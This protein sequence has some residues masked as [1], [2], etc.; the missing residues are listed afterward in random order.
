MF[1]IYKKV[2]GDSADFNSYV[3]LDQFSGKVLSVHDSR[4]GG[5]GDR[6]L[7]SFAPLHYGT[8]GGLPTRILYVFVG[9]S[10]T[11]LLITGFVMWQYRHRSISDSLIDAKELAEQRRT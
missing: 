8:F 1:E 9:L 7:N 6:V 3:K 2:P 4:R 10:P 11:V 5:L